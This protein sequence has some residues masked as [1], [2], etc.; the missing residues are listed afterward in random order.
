LEYILV[1]S[2]N[3]LHHI[4]KTPLVKLEKIAK[5]IYSSI[6]A[7]LEMFNPCGSVKDRAALFM[8]QDA[9]K[10]NLIKP[11]GTLVESSSGNTGAALAMIAGVKGYKCIIATPDK[12]SEE[13]ID[14]MKNLGAKVIITPTDV[15]PES[16][17]SY[18]NIGKK[19]ANETPGAFYTDQ[20]HNI[21][22]I[23][24]HYYTT[25]PEIWRQTQGKIDVLIA[26]IGTGGTIL[27]TGRY[28]KEKNPAIQVIA[29]DPIGSVYYEYFKNKTLPPPKVYKIEGIGE[30]F[31][32]EVIDFDMIDDIIQVSDKDSFLTARKLA[33]EEGIVAGGSSGSALWAALKFAGEQKD[34][35]NIVTIFPDSGVRYLS[36]IYNDTWMKKN[37]FLL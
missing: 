31:V 11:G 6:Y 20:C 29:V 9:E 23:D 10:R 37:G 34:K 18:Y 19:I 24:A 1:F 4:G 21:Q 25:G 33:V 14:F 7:K 16:P 8:V 17:D 36:K 26:G 27:G 12:M 3:I 28:L 5:N 30:D 2:K 32:S 22:N 13:K 15:P 35:K